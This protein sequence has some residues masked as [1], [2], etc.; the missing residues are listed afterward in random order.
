MSHTP[1][2]TFSIVSPWGVRGEGW[3]P[4]RAGSSDMVD[5]SV[6]L[7]EGGREGGRERERKRER[8]WHKQW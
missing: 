7:R 8:N 3:R 2:F 1:S 6:G 4:R 5:H